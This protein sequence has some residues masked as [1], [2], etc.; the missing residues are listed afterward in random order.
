VKLGESRKAPVK[1][2]ADILG[3]K[4]IVSTTSTHCLFDHLCRLLHPVSEGLLSS[5]WSRSAYLVPQTLNKTCTNMM[6]ILPRLKQAVELSFQLFIYVHTIL[7][8]YF[9]APW[10]STNLEAEN[11]LEPTH[12]FTHQVV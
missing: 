7:K 11:G 4:C 10:V 3:K 9:L 6:L 8:G 1:A 12:K 5:I 2:S